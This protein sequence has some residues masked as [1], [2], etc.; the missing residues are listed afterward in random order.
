MTFCEC[1]IHSEGYVQKFA[2]TFFEGRPRERASIRL[3]V[4]T[5]SDE[6]GGQRRNRGKIIFI[7]KNYCKRTLKPNILLKSNKYFSLT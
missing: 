4:T 2:E 1:E 3:Y 7:I 5:S 6:D